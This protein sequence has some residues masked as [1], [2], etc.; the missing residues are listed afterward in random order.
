MLPE[1]GRFI[2][3]KISLIKFLQILDNILEAKWK[4]CLRR[5][6]DVFE[7]GSRGELLRLES[8][9]AETV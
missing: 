9:V 5:D 2:F 7:P 1:Y 6:A 4:T 3:S 8:Q